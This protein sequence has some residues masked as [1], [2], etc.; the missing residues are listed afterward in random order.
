M[1]KLGKNKIMVVSRDLGLSHIGSNI[2][3]LP[4]LDKIYRH[5]KETDIVILDNAHAHLAHVVARAKGFAGTIKAI[6]TVI[7][8]FGIHCDRRAGCDAS[9]GS[10]G[11]G[12]GIA[13]GYALANPKRM[14]Y[15]VV[16]DGGLNE[17]STWEAL[18]LIDK[19]RI[20]N[21]EIHVNANGF[22][23]LEPVN[24]D[25][26]KK[27]LNIFTKVIVHR[28]SNGKGFEGVGGHYAKVS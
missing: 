15:V 23:A 14:V 13:I 28:T 21:I 20:K 26:L 8:G 27:R 6:E 12:L 16:S 1:S 17:G 7:T 2:S 11:H 10:L 19:L 18:R 25:L 5:K 4:I 24:I 3:C 22:S 9:G